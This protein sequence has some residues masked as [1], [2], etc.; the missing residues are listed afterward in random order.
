[1][2]IGGFHS[3]RYKSTRARKGT[4]PLVM[5]ECRIHLWYL[6][7]PKE[8]QS[9]QVTREDGITPIRGQLA[10]LFASDGSSVLICP[11]GCP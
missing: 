2:F 3:L 9:P 7:H 10:V 1:M 4:L 8:V 11:K 5:D 6:L